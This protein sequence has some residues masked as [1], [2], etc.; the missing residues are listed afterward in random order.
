ME[1]LSAQDMPPKINKKGTGKK[2]FIYIGNDDVVESK[3]IISILEYQLIHS[4]PKLQQLIK[5][6]KRTNQVF[7]SF[8]DAKSIVITDD[9]ICYSPLSTLTLKKRKNYMQAMNQ[10]EK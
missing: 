6:R 9:C 3:T 5:D 4:S 10:V 2:L 8:K 1:F 7:G